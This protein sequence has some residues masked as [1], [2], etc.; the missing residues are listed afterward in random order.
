MGHRLL[1][2]EYLVPT[3]LSVPNFMFAN[4]NNVFVSASKD[5]IFGTS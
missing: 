3:L 5:G 2:F 4:I 1:S